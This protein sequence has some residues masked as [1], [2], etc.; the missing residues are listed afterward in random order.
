MTTS[1]PGLWIDYLK[2]PLRLS[3][4]RCIQPVIYSAWG[5]QDSHSLPAVVTDFACLFW[6]RICET[7]A[8]AKIN[9]MLFCS[10]S[11]T[12]IVTDS[13]IFNACW[14]LYQDILYSIC[15]WA[16]C[17]PTPV[18]CLG[19]EAMAANSFTVWSLL[20]PGSTPN[21]TQESCGYWH[22]NPLRRLIFYDSLLFQCVSIAVFILSGKHIIQRGIFQIQYAAKWKFFKVKTE[23]KT[24]SFQAFAHEHGFLYRSLLKQRS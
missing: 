12:N 23:N 1:Y 2:K 13:I 15:F 20:S 24:G 21:C 17:S 11:H 4:M 6:T 7:S 19:H 10:L 18:S 14:W 5:Y 9:E 22:S 8:S 3:S 16:V